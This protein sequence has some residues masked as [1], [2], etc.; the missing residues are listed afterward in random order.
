MHHGLRGPG[1]G[2]WVGGL[3]LR[4]DDTVSRV[5]SSGLCVKDFRF[6]V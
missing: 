6:G 5:Y 2:M 4:V 1:K 3:G